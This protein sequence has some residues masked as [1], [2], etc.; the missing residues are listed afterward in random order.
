[1]AQVKLLTSMAGIHFSHDE[2][3]VIDCNEA[4]K[5]RYIAAGIAEAVG[6]VAPAIERSTPKKSRI[7]KAVKEY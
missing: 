1:M 2:G 3:D 6:T 7:E 5:A 4:E